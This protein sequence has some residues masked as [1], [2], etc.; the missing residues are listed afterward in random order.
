MPKSLKTHHLDQ[1]FKWKFYVLLTVHLSYNL[2]QWPTWS[3]LALFC[4]M[5]TTIRYMFRASGGW[6][7]LMQHLISSS[8]SVAIW[9]TGW[10][11]TVLSQPVH[12]MAT[13]WEDDTRCCISTIQP[14]DDEH[15]MLETC[16][17]L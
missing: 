7:V 8:Q 16:R 17:R 5:F 1:K 3:T 6:I 4:N 14:P 11:R 12:W 10:E 2:G 9:C 15:I 13:D